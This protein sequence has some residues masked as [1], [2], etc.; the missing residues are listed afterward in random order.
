MWFE[1]IL[2]LTSSTE[3]L[4]TLEAEKWNLVSEESQL[5]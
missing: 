2:S 5:I 4:Q 3:K 1:Y